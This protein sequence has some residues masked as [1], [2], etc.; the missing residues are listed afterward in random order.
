MKEQQSYPAS[1][2]PNY[3]LDVYLP[4]SH[5]DWALLDLVLAAQSMNEVTGA[6]IQVSRSLIYF[7]SS[8]LVS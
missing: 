2:P 5:K 7:S 1:F 6:T 3:M 8:V 4:E